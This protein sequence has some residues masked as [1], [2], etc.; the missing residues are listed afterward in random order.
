MLLVLLDLELLLQQDLRLKLLLQRHQLVQTIACE[1]IAVKARR[2]NVSWIRS[3][4]L[5][6]QYLAE[7]SG[8]G[9]TSTN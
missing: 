5:L 1:R 3:T 2:E 8:A 7:A 4:N 9:S 6:S